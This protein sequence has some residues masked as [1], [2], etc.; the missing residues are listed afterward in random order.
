MNTFHTQRHFSAS[1]QTI[2]EAIQDPVRLAKWWGPA[3]FSNQIDLFDFRT[4]GQ[5]HFKMIAPDGSIYPNESVFTQIEPNRRVV[6][7]HINHPHFELAINLAPA[8]S[9][10]LLLW[11]QTFDDAAVATAM[12]PIVESANEQNLDR[13]EAELGLSPSA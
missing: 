3:G 1:A 7:R 4:G 10:T 6:I 12:Q 8:P 2:F 11:D 13:L 9:G 5:W